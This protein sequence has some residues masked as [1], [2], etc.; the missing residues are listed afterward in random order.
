MGLNLKNVKYYVLVQLEHGLYD[1]LANVC[2][3]F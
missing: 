2:T 1:F 3:I